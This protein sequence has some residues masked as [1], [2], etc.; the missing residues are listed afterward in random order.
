MASHFTLMQKQLCQD[1][2]CPFTSTIY[3]MGIRPKSHPYSPSAFLHFGCYQAVHC[4]IAPVYGGSTNCNLK[5]THANR[6]NAS[7]WRNIYTNLKTESLF[8]VAWKPFLLLH[9]QHFSICF[10]FLS[11]QH[12]SKFKL[13][14]MPSWFSCALSICVCFLTFQFVELSGPPYILVGMK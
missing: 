6:Q 13:V 14:E 2:S 10:C 12:F 8:S 7:K 5:K 9:M 1:L 11:L 3:K 4:F